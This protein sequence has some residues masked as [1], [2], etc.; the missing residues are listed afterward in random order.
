MNFLI[1]GGTGYLGK[2]LICH[3]LQD[4]DNRIICIKRKE[5]DFGKPAFVSGKERLEFWDID[6]AIAKKILRKSKL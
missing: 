2:K 6:A 1:L 5:S 4:K 3:L